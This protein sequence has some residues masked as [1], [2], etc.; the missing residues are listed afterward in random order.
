M[1][2]EGNGEIICPS[3]GWRNRAG[4]NFCGVCGHS[5]RVGLVCKSCGAAVEG[6]YRFCGRCGGRVDGELAAAIASIRMMRQR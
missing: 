4:A 3:C 1:S 2:G 6:A 5:L